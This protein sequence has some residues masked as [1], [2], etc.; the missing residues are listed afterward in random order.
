MGFHE[1]TLLSIND[2]H[3]ETLLSINDSHEETLLSINDGELSESDRNDSNI[4][5]DVTHTKY[6]SIPMN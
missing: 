3:E 4:K 6:T 2:S 5:L 1:E